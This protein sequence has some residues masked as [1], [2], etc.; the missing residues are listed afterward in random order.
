MF[1][2]LLWIVERIMDVFVWLTVDLPLAVFLFCFGLSM[3]AFI[4]PFRFGIRCIGCAVRVLNR[5][6]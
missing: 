5:L 6:F 1:Q 4:F 2:G 3:C